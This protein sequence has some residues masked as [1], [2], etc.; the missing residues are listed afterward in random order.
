MGTAE[1]RAREKEKRRQDIIDAAE[2]IFLNQELEDTTMDHIANEAE[3]SKGTLYLYFKSKEDLFFAV[4]LRHRKILQEMLEKE[5][6][7]RG[8]TVEK[9]K[10]FGDVHWNFY[11]EYPQYS[12]IFLSVGPLE[13]AKLAAESPY[14]SDYN[15]ISLWIDAEL[16]KLIE[17]GKSENIIKGDVNPQFASLNILIFISGMMQ[18]IVHQG[19]LMEKNM[20]MLP[21]NLYNYGL[22]MIDASLMA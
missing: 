5:L 1:R 16:K 14:A 21:E 13:A 4:R 18:S 8:S 20:N 10:A 2:T 7:T 11:K 9:L 12:K 19:E 17:Q 22:G 6:E 15:D 3:L